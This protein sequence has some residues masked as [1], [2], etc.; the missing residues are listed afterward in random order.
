M[1]DLNGQT[2]SILF[3][4][5]VLLRSR[6]FEALLLG[7]CGY[8]TISGCLTA[9]PDQLDDAN[10]VTRNPLLQSGQPW[11]KLLTEE[12]Y[13]QHIPVTMIS[14]RL[15]TELF[16]LDAGWA[17]RLGNL[18]IHTASA[19]LI[20]AV[21]ERL[22]LTRGEALCVAVFWAVHPMACETVGWVSQRRN[23]LGFFFGILALYARIRFIGRWW[24]W[25]L[26]PLAFL[27]ALFSCPLALGWLPIFVALEALGSPLRLAGTGSPQGPGHDAK[28]W[29]GLLPSFLAALVVARLGMSGYAE[30]MR[31][32][33]GGSAFA[34]LLTD[35]DIFL[36]YLANLLWPLRLSAMYGIEAIESLGDPR[37]WVNAFVWIALL[38]GSLGV[39]RS[40]RRAAYGWLWFF[41]GLGPASNLVAI[42]YPMQDRYV[43]LS[44]VGFFLVLVETVAGMAQRWTALDRPWLRALFP[45]PFV[46]FLAL[47]AADRSADWSDSAR[48]MR[49][50]VEVQPEAALAHIFH[51]R[52][53]I[54][55]AEDHRR[56]GDGER[57][58]ATGREAVRHLEKGLSLPDAYL[59]NPLFAE[60]LMA[61]S[62]LLAGES[63]KAIDRLEGRLPVPEASMTKSTDR[64]AAYPY[65]GSRFAFTYHLSRPALSEG[66]R[67]LATA[68]L[69][70]FLKRPLSYDEARP[71]LKHAA[72]NGILALKAHPGSAEAQCLRACIL[73]A[74]E[75]F[76]RQDIS[77][78]EALGEARARASATEPELLLLAE[79]EA[80]REDL[81]RNLSLARLRALGCL[82]L[83]QVCFRPLLER[84]SCRVEERE[85]QG[86]EDGLAWCRRAQELDTTLGMAFLYEARIRHFLMEAARAAGAAQIVELHRA[87]CVAALRKVPSESACYPLAKKNLDALGS[88]RIFFL[89]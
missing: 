54:R 68:W 56:A 70:E 3:R 81:K 78:E 76:V 82:G 19:L 43:Y 25:V 34:A 2:A 13:Y 49:R 27:L 47:V 83:A 8:L 45:L 26:P 52:Q 87:A 17:F 28:G 84:K 53:L 31:P 32:P 5:G 12:T 14:L 1:R 50:A 66:Y 69:H 60:I 46:L 11:S 61:N 35:T 24:C 62:L 4:A 9:P 75:S 15:N 55:M 41:G 42:G 29:L 23:A 22:G 16:G 36:Q 73:L 51:A 40:R 63:S 64:S 48:L 71:L 88:G 65:V 44:S 38:C 57:A 58:A 86:I 74:E 18:L 72:A 89:P 30:T 59:Y 20:M 6:L 39:A 80:V 67:Q 21:L 10:Y 37:F 7:L 77:R 85:R 79:I 33:P